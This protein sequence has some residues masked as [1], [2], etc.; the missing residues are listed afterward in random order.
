MKTKIT[1][2]STPTKNYQKHSLTMEFEI[3]YETIVELNQK[4]DDHQTY[5]NSRALKGLKDQ[6]EKVKTI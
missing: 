3:V 4:V 6:I 5:V 1:I 2:E